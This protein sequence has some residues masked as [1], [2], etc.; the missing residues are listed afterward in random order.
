M[1]SSAAGAV[2]L[3]LMLAFCA[4]VAS[5]AS[6]PAPNYYTLE[7]ST[8][9]EPAIRE[10]PLPYTLVIA[11]FGA[12]QPYDSRRI[13]WRAGSN[14]LGYY[15]REKWASLPE[16]M[17]SYRLHERA[18]GSNMFRHV[19]LG[20]DA[21]N[22][23]LILRG[24]ITSFEELDTHDGWFGKVE[25]WAELAQKDGTVVWSGIVG[26]TERATEQNVDASVRAI[27]EACEVVISSLLSHIDDS[28]RESSSE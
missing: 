9:A 13:V 1:H 7:P 8:D 2:R 16:E 21:D 26:H 25:M 23:D 4:V 12:E 18:Y 3:A 10:T 19:S 11:R 24:R 28:L 15:P 5:C 17:F 20:V 6:T 22:A 14:R 27:T